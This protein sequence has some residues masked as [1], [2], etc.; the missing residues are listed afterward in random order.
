[1]EGKDLL[2]VAV[3]LQKQGIKKIDSPHIACTIDA[4]ADYFLTTDDGILRKAV[5]I[6]GVRVDEPIG[7]IK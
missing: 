2:E 3:N 5:R 7:F 4:E 1:M 6:Q